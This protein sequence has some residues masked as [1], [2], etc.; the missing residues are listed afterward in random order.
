MGGKVFFVGQSKNATFRLKP[1]VR[2]TTIGRETL[3][4][5]KY[6]ATFSNH[7]HYCVLQS[8]TTNHMIFTTHPLLYYLFCACLT[9]SPFSPEGERENVGC[10]K[11]REPLA[12]AGEVAQ[13]ICRRPTH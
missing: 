3:N 13:R 1:S 8:V 11:T 5:L 10:S 4:N 7:L 12:Q 6:F 2:F 9:N